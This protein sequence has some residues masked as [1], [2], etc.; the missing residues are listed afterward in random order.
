MLTKAKI[1]FLKTANYLELL[2]AKRL[3]RKEK[4]QPLGITISVK[5]LGRKCKFNFRK[6]KNKHFAVL[7]DLEREIVK[8]CVILLSCTVR[9]T[10]LFT[11]PEVKDEKMIGEAEYK[12]IPCAG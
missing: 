2:Y 12:D 9:M 11:L 10:M 6:V 3:E 1:V 8:V 4:S 7:V 5:C